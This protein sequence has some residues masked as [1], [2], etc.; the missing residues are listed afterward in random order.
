MT[1]TK[2]ANSI[3]NDTR[4]INPLYKIYTANSTQDNTKKREASIG[5]AIALHPILQTYIYNI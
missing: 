5:T 2:L 3:Y 4:L 1:E